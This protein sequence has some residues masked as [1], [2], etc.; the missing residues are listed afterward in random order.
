[1]DQIEKNNCM[2]VWLQFIDKLELI[3]EQKPNIPHVSTVQSTKSKPS[4][5]YL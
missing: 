3:E 5:K 1:M 4:H 2:S